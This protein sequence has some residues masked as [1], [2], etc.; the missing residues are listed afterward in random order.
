MKAAQTHFS[1]LQAGIHVTLKLIWVT[2][3]PAIALTATYHQG[4]N[5]FCQHDCLQSSKY[6]AHTAP[7][8]LG[9]N[10]GVVS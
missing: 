9:I 2:G 8:T 6:A 1:S 3:R 4:I 5:S 10:W 7:V